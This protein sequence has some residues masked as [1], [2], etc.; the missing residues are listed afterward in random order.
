MGLA[1]IG[2]FSFI[3]ASLGVTLH[4][5]SGFLY[6][7]AVAVSAVTTLLTPYL[8][9]GADGLVTWFDREAPRTLVGYLELYTQWV[10]QLGGHRHASMASRFVRKWLWQMGLNAALIASVFAAMAFIAKNPPSW[11]RQ[12]GLDE[13]TVN[14]ALWLVAILL[15]LPLL[16]ATFRKLQALGLLVAELKVSRAAAGERTV[17]IRAVIAHVIPLAGIV[18]L[19]L[20]VLAL[21]STVLPPLK[22]LVLL[23]IVV[24]LITGLLWRSFIKIYARAQVSLEQTFAQPSPPR[25]EPVPAPLPGILRDADLDTVGVVAGSEAAGKLIRE[26][27]LRTATGASIVGIERN[28][29][30]IINPGPDEELQTGDRV[31]ILGNRGQLD[32]ARALFENPATPRT[33]Q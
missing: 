16:I 7:V 17:A 6:P 1:Q 5:T 21:S 14:S 9:K 12:V 28:G 15:A 19:G 33:G 22:V 23:L 24:G 27:R 20:Y 2:E 3:I 26:L 31:L 10:G 8:I 13:G 30:S 11:L 29:A 4:V 25:H 32:A 18:A